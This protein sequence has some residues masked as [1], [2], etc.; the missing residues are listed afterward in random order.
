MPVGRGANMIARMSRQSL[1]AG[2]QPNQLGSEPRGLCWSRRSARFRS[3]VV[4]TVAG[5]GRDRCVARSESCAPSVASLRLCGNQPAKILLAILLL[6]APNSPA[7][8]IAWTRMTGQ[9][10]VECSPILVEHEGG[11]SLLTVNRGG[12]LML[13]GLDGTDRGGGPDGRV[14]SLPKGTWSSSPLEVQGNGEIRFVLCSVEGLAVGLD[15]KCAVRWQHQLPNQSM[16]ATR[17]KTP[18]RGTARSAGGERK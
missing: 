16:H 15:D 11:S 13:W 3:C 2:R 7:L 17:R 5:G 1:S 10:P 8:E 9:F 12:E 18:A 6:L 4:L 14:G